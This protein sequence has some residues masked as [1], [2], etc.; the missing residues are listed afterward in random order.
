MKVSKLI[1]HLQAKMEHL[2]DVEV[3]A[4]TT[5]KEEFREV[6]TTE[7]ALDD[8]GEFIGIVVSEEIKLQ[9]KKYI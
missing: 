3:W 2:G 8:E 6:L 7:I 9:K 4:F 1:N 5:D